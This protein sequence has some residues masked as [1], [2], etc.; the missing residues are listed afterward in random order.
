MKLRIRGNSIRLRLLQ[1]EVAQLADTGSVSESVEFGPKNRLTYQIMSDQAA[2][3]VNAAFDQQT[4]TVTVP[5]T[6]VLEWAK[7]DGVGIDAE[8]N[9]L[10]ILIEKDFACLT[11]TDEPDNLDAFPNPELACT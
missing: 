6:E 11:R 9:G 5:E 1:S 3:S 7:T 10:S 4:L 2:G 8:S